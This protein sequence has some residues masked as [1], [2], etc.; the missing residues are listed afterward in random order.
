MLIHKSF[1]LLGRRARDVI[2]GLEGVIDSICFDLYGCIQ[3]SLRPDGFTD[4]G[5]V[6]PAHW[7]DIKRLVASGDP[8]MPVPD[9]SLPE[10]GPA[11]KAAR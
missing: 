6:K 10:V 2:T 3:A 9:F 7:Y 1:E 8:L 4:K 11:D 5:E